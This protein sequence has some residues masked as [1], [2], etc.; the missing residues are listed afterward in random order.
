MLKV[1]LSCLLALSMVG[2]SMMQKRTPN[3]EVILKDQKG[4]AHQPPVAPTTTDA[5]A[6]TPVAPNDKELA[7]AQAQATEMKEAV[8]AAAQHIQAKHS[9]HPREPGPI[10][11]DKALGWLKNGNTRFGKGLF[12]NDGASPK[13]RARLTTGQ[14]PHSIVLSCSD[15]RVP[16]EVV[17]DQ[18]LGEIFVIRTAGQDVDDNVIASIEYAV[19]HLG[20][21][22]LVVMGHESCGGIK[23]AL[24]ALQGADLGSPSLNAWANELKPHLQSHAGKTPSQGLLEESWSNVSGVE[25][26]LL[27][28][29]ALLRD[30]VASGGV[31]IVKAMYHLESGNVEWR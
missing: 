19:S 20:S 2:C 21:N 11:A 1:I 23:A 26:D 15:S 25:K 27:E 13:D 16:P 3:Q 31:K 5:K 8:A 7:A 9:E 6:I 29:S 22:L 12:R 10:P 17:F 14:K 30:A 18:K 4:A 24:S 28:R